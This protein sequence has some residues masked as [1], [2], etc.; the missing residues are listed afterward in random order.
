MVSRSSGD[1]DLAP[2]LV[3]T[4]SSSRNTPTDDSFPKAAE[5][6]SKTCKKDDHERKQVEAKDACPEI[7]EDD[8]NVR[9]SLSCT[10]I[11]TIDL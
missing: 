5:F 1:S 3:G 2:T 11:H 8:I 4:N 9:N 10:T 7:C 6:D